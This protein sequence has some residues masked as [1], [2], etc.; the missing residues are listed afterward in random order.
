M[1]TTF[2]STTYIH[3]SLGQFGFRLVYGFR[4]ALLQTAHAVN[5][6]PD[7][8]YP[9]G[10]T[11]EGQNALF[12]LTGGNYNTADGDI[13][14]SKPHRR[15]LLHGYRRRDAPCEQRRQDTAIGAG[16]LLSNTVGEE[17]TATGAFA[18]FSNT[19]AAANTA[20]RSNPALVKTRQATRGSNT[21]DGAGR[22]EST[23]GEGGRRDEG[24]LAGALHNWRRQH[25]HGFS[26][27]PTQRLR[28]LQHGHWPFCPG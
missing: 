9:G 24:T 23:R 2:V 4:F 18:L 10:N 8:G 12:S 28:Q 7:G 22:F 1:N 6:P 13:L 15:R 20:K 27:A 19:P 5:P 11:A 14:A 16:A 26:S 21:A 25:G 3:R 17:N